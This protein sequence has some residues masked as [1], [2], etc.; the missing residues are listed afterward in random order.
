MKLNIYSNEDKSDSKLIKSKAILKIVKSKYILRKIFNH[1]P[2]LKTLNIIKYNKNIQNILNINSEDYEYFSEI[3]IEIKP[4]KN[5][6]GNITKTLEK[7]DKPYYHIY[8]NDDKEEY[9]SYYLPE[10]RDVNKIRIIIDKEVK[11]LA[12]IFYYCDKI[13]SINFIRFYRSNINDMSCMFERCKSLK[14][15]NF[16][17]FNT[18]NVKYMENMF[19]KCLSLKKLDLSNFNTKNVI[20]M[21]SMFSKCYALEELNI[22]SDFNIKPGTNTTNMLYGCS[23]SI[24]CEFTTLFPYIKKNAF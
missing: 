7:N 11:S 22:S 20:N 8:I 9:K 17:N 13:E 15:I 4:I 19:K 6:F 24:K 18:K 14:E 5:A 21:A 3:E 23:S 1:F 2:K 10:K 16:S 12:N